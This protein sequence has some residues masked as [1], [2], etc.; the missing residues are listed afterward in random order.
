MLDFLVLYFLVPLFLWFIISWKSTKN[1]PKS[2]PF[3]GSFLAIYKNED[4]FIQWTADF[5]KSSPTSTFVLHRPFGRRQVFTANPANVQH[6]LKTH[7]HIYQK[8]DLA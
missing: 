7:F 4:R 8:G 6:M 2:Y 3:I 5:V 1:T